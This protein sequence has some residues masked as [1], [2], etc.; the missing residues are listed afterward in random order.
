MTAKLSK[1]NQHCQIIQLKIFNLELT[2]SLTSSKAPNLH[3][4]ICSEMNT[5]SVTKKDYCKRKGVDISSCF[6]WKLLLLIV[7]RFSNMLRNPISCLSCLLC[8]WGCINSHS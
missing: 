3:S 4:V 8:Y 6:F 1:L 5:A 7:K 2:F